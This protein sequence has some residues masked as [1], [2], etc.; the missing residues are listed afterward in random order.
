M[1]NKLRPLLISILL[2]SCV[3]FLNC[4][5]EETAECK[6][7]YALTAIQQQAEFRAYSMDKQLAIYLCGMRREP[8]DM[9]L[10]GYISDRG[11]EVIPYLLERLEAEKSE[12]D[13]RNILFIFDVMFNRGSL[14]GK[15]D[16]IGQLRQVVA[17]MKVNVIKQDSQ[18]MLARIEKNNAG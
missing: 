17:A 9:G 3:F 13:Q 18:E 5:G 10:A 1:Q 6:G 2:L 16:V 4:R 15:Q 11:E 8:P 7:F 14:H 12:V